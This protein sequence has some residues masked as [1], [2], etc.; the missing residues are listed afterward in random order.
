[1]L[2]PRIRLYSTVFT[3]LTLGLL[4][5]PLQAQDMQSSPTTRY[6]YG[7]PAHATPTIWR[8]MGGVGIALSNPKAINFTNLLHSPPPTPSPS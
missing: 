3:I 6:G 7:L 4:S 2:S 5:T 8:G 1:M